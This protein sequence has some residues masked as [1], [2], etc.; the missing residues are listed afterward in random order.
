MSQKTRERIESLV[1]VTVVTVLVWLFAEGEVIKPY[2]PTLQVRF[3]SPSEDEPLLIEISDTSTP[4]EAGEGQSLSVRVQLR[5]SAGQR[6]EVERRFQGRPI[7]IPVADPTGPAGRTQTIDL[8]A[9]LANSALGELGVNVRDTTPDSVTVAVEPMRTVSLPIEVRA[10]GQRLAEPPSVEPAE[11]EVQAPASEVAQIEGRRVVAAIDEM[12]LDEIEPGK[13]HT[14]P[15]V[16]LQLPQLPPW[17]DRQHLSLMTNTAAV[18]VTLK[19]QTRQAGLEL[20]RM[21]VNVVASWQ[22]LEAYTL[23]IL[24]PQRVVNNVRL[25]GPAKLISQIENGRIDVRAEV[26]PSYEQLQSGIRTYPVLI[27]A[28]PEV[29]IASDLPEVT[30]DA[31]PR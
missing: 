5:A 23:R 25:K 21:P 1:L 3:V 15:N 30:I 2:E 17:I 4:G 22:V 19:E 7:E 20:N 16:V 10:H 26:R 24:E 29:Q 13:T 9:R 12:R 6:Q 18:T 8:R 14:F 11:V 31:E 27:E 28:P